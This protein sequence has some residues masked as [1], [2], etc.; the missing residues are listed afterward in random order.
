MCG[1]ASNVCKRN[2]RRVSTHNQVHAEMQ[3]GYCEYAMVRPDPANEATRRV[4]NTENAQRKAAR[5][6]QKWNWAA[7]CER[8]REPGCERE[9][10][11]RGAS[12]RCQRIAQEAS[13]HLHVAPVIS[14]KR[15]LI[16]SH[17]PTINLM[18]RAWKH[19]SQMSISRRNVKGKVKRFQDSLVS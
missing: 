5:P 13:R 18:Q 9:R 2:V 1:S 14:R 6:R 12:I 16:Q 11:P 19:T 8:D 7:E 15:I 4:I 3:T 17:P 10:R